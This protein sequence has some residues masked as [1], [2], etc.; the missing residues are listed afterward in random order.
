MA[1][2]EMFDVAGIPISPF[3]KGRRS[4][5]TSIGSIASLATLIFI[6]VF[7][8]LQVFEVINKKNNVLNSNLRRDMLNEPE[9]FDLTQYGFQLGIKVLDKNTFHEVE[10][11]ERLFNYRFINFTQLQEGEDTPLKVK[12]IPDV[13]CGDR[14]ID[15]VGQQ[16]SDAFYL[17]GYRCPDVSSL[18]L[19]GQY[20][21]PSTIAF[22]F[23]VYSCRNGT[24]PIVCAPPEEIEV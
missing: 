4:Y 14:F 2:F 24:S 23:N 5:K 19:Q 21:S 3:V 15:T 8:I 7:V 9:L 10:N 22:G 18:T 20:S 16:T 11:Y 6:V 13:V 1:F 12:T 17:S